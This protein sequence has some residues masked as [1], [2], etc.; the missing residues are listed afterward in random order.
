LIYCQEN[1]AFDLTEMRYIYIRMFDQTLK[2]QNRSPAFKVDPI[3]EM[4]IRIDRVVAEIH[5]PTNAF[6]V[7]DPSN[8]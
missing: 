3:E 5:S 8:H 2:T 1:T 4:R 7:L 6:V